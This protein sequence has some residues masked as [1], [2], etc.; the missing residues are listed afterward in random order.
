[1]IFALAR[2]A[3]QL[4]VVPFRFKGYQN[5]V[6]TQN[7]LQ[8]LFVKHFGFHDSHFMNAVNEA[9]CNAARYAK[10]GPSNTDVEIDVEI[11]ESDLSV[12]VRSDT[13]HSDAKK[14]QMQLR[15]LAANPKLASKDWGDYTLASDMSRG[16][17]Y[18]LMACD[19]V[20][21][22]SDMSSVKLSVGLPHHE[23]DLE[24]SISFLVPKF[25][26]RTKGVIS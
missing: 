12:V 2:R 9:V 22:E 11:T 16:F 24:R 8:K 26:V 10:A 4:H 21:V 13:R 3:F 18:M 20:L 23:R 7:S 25:F 15:S 19:Y 5:Y 17:W 1:M 14:I 6:E